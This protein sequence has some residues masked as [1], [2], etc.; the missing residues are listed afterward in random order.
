MATNVGSW[1]RD[2]GRSSPVFAFSS[3][4]LQNFAPSCLS[5]E[6]EWGTHCPPPLP[7]PR[8]LSSVLH[9]GLGSERTE[10]PYPAVTRLSMSY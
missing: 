3:G 7:P 10:N 9:R 2:G 8:E 4:C 1:D 6:G 5:S